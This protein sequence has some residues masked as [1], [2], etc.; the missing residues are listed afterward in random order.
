MSNGS[1]LV[2][3]T[4]VRTRLPWVS[5]APF[6]SPVVPLVNTISASV[7]GVTR[8]GGSGV[9]TACLVDERL[10]PQHGQPK[11]TGGGIRLAAGED[12]LRVGLAD[13]LPAELDGVAHVERHRDGAEVGAREQP[14]A[15]LGAV[16][17]PHDDAVALPHPV[18]PQDAPRHG[19]RCPPG[20]G[21]A[22]SGYGRTAGSG[23]PGGGRTARLRAGPGRPGSTGF[24]RSA[25]CGPSPAAQCVPL[26][27]FAR[28]SP[29]PPSMAAKWP[30]TMVSMSRA[31]RRRIDLQA[32]A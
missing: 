5:I 16:D 25:R 28:T 10:D 4:A 3:A 15:P 14:D 17:R 21:S 30:K 18:V 6:G 8:A 26:T 7:S 24:R 29:A 13:D 9:C 2:M 11:G 12:E 31:A 23:A 22:M 1:T 20:R 19:E 32:R 27:S